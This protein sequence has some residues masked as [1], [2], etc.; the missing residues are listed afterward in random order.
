MKQ[1]ITVRS[2]AYYSQEDGQ[3]EF[4]LK[5]MLEI[6]IVH[7]DGQIYKAVKSGI[8]SAYKFGESRF[9]VSPE[10]LDQLIVDLKLHQKKLEGIRKN[11]D[12]LNAMVRHITLSE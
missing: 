3:K 4:E 2:N 9:I 10:L 1:M 6:V 5:P 11:A 8:E 12:Q 7:T